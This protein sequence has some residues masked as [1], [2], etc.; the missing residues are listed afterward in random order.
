MTKKIIF[1][2]SVIVAT[3][4]VVVGATTAYFN[5]TETSTGNV[6]TAGS[7]DMT[8][9]SFGAIYN[10]EDVNNTSWSARNLTE[11]KFFELEDLKPADIYNRSISVHVDSNPAWLCIG[12]KNTNDQENGINEAE[13]DAGDVSNPQGELSKNV[14]VLVWKE[15]IPDLVHQTNE[16]ILI[17]SFFDVFIDLP[18]RD[19]TTGTGP[20]SPIETELLAMSLC[21]GTHVIAPGPGF[22]GAVSCDG[23]T[24]GDQAQT[25]SLLADL[26]IYG[27]Q[28]RNN[29]NFKCSELG[30][31]PE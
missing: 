9:D 1:S 2:L 12:A 17:N 25:D 23:S 24:M 22:G 27:E 8:V 4:V 21:G 20:T 13:D 15:I 14:D 6:F 29:P 18:L 31:R 30:G 7:I 26:V 19:S 16:P 3:A 5:D 11:E 10:G 28:H